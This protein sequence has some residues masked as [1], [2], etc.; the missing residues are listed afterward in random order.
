VSDL[1]RSRV[2]D[3]DFLCHQ[4]GGAPNCIGPGGGHLKPLL[5]IIDDEGE[6]RGWVGVEASLSKQVYG[7]AI[8]TI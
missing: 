6:F 1:A 2:F 3:T 5:Q 4:L 7:G 8:V